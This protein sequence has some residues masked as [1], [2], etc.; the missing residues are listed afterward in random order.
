MKNPKISICIPTYNRLNYL[1][2][3][4]NSCLNQSFQDFEIIITDN[5]DDDESRCYIS[6]L[7][8]KK[9]RYFKNESNLGFTRNFNMAITKAR[10]EYIKVLMDDDLMDPAALS[11][12]AKILDD[13]PTVGVVMSP[14]NVINQK[15]EKDYY[16]AY[17]IKKVHCLYRYQ[18]FN[19]LIPR[20]RILLDFL[21]KKYPCCVPSALLYRRE[22][23]K[24]LGGLDLS[25]KFATD[26]EICMRIAKKYDFYYIDKLLTSWRCSTTSLTVNLHK[27]GNDAEEFYY[28]TE[29]FLYDSDVF[30]KM[31]LLRWEK[32]RQEAYMF[33]T[34]RCFLSVLAGIKTNNF[35]LII[36]VFK[37]I[38]KKDP[39]VLK[40]LPKVIFNLFLEILVGIGSWVIPSKLNQPRST[41]Y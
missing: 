14:M 38:F 12:M 1:R 16:R 41:I 34:K 25:M 31:S 10:G 4:I 19:G 27:T 18:K 24:T 15:G 11:T 20:A 30:E 2:L 6:Q 7:N 29:K 17:L 32:I 22:C 37:L 21:T 26:V 9:I 13:Y 5:S 39:Y 33:A 3:A 35:R 36:N 40:N 28:L 23:F 8:D